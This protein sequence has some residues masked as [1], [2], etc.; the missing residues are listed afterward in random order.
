MET[1]RWL[2]RFAKRRGS[3]GMAATRILEEARRR[4][5]FPAVEFRDMRLG[6]E[7]HSSKE[8]AFKWALLTCNGS[9]IRRSVRK[10]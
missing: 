9:S 10:S 5:D 1:R 6:R 7:S 8:R 2:E 3:P 4:E